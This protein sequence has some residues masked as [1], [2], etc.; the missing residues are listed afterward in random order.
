MSISSLKLKFILAFAAIIATAAIAFFILLLLI[1]G[2]NWHSEI[3]NISGRQRML[4]QKIA[5]LS[6]ELASTDD[7]NQKNQLHGDLKSSISAMRSSHNDLVHGIG[8]HHY[9]GHRLEVMDEI[10]FE[11][12]HFLDKMTADFLRDATTLSNQAGK[13]KPDNK[14]LQT[15]LQSA[16]KLL[17]SLDVVVKHHQLMSE[18]DLSTLSRIIILFFA[19]ITAISFLSYL[20][21]V[22]PTLSRVRNDAMKLEKQ[23]KKLGQLSTMDELTNIENRRGFNDYMIKEWDRAK[24]SKK[25]LSIIMMD[26]DYFKKYNDKLGH[27]AGDECLASIAALLKSTFRRPGDF[28]ARY[29]GEEFI[30]VL[31]DTDLD[32][33]KKLA[34]N[35]RKGVEGLYIVHPD[36]TV[37]EVV[38]ISLG[39]ATSTKNSSTFEALIK[40]ADN[41]LYVAKEKGRNRVRSTYDDKI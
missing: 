5:L 15:I 37:S 25:P 33:A 1:N 24:R 38:T 14:N 34:E 30:S 11:E 40:T 19:V 4:S 8:A 39:V 22:S 27:P 35:L 36:S 41:E 6:L 3:I 32:G 26:I 21:I 7:K 9:L 13:I 31:P 23:N 29:G 16:P 18:Q 20:Y 2:E 10:Y 17:I 12:P 28:I